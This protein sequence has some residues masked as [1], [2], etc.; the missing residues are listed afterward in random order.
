MKKIRYSISAGLLAAMLTL[1]ACNGGAD[2]GGNTTAATV[3]DDPPLTRVDRS[4]ETTKSAENDTEA[5][6]AQTAANLPDFSAI[7]AGNGSSSTVWGQLDASA[8]QEII[9]AAK[10]EG[11]DVTFDEDGRMTI[12]GGDGVNFVQN[13]DGT[14]NV[15]TEDGNVV[16][17]GGNWPDNAF[18][19][20]IPKPD[21]P[22]LAANTSEDEFTAAFQ[23]VTVDQIR[24]YAAKL[25]ACGFTID[26]EE[27][28]QTTY[29]VVVY[30]YN[31][32]HAD[33][34][35]VDLSFAAGQCG[36]TICKE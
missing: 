36:L 18:T 13:A 33:G 24:A 30:T 31:A 20:L 1:T 8:K 6:P 10:A 17:Y 9:A 28:D 27:E 35:Y 22:I 12:K 25:K 32:Y 29:G 5:A 23:N 2:K 7:V 14:W 15:K 26:A 19:R 4:E 21:F 34:Y 3:D 16:Q 11:Y